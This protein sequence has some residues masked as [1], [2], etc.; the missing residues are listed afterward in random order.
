MSLNRRMIL[1]TSLVLAVF[2]ALTTL[3]LDRAF[4]DNARAA[5]QERLLGQLY[6]LIAA[7]RALSKKARSKASVVNTINTANT[8]LALRI[9]RRFNDITVPLPR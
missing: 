8:K 9:M 3:A 7:A 5:R 2:M 6:L 1:S 4:F